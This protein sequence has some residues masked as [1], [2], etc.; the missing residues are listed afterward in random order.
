M[1]KNKLKVLKEVG[2]RIHKTCMFCAHKDIPYASNWGGCKLHTYNHLKHTKESK[3]LSIHKS[4]SCDSFE[5]NEDEL[6]TIHGFV[7]L[8]E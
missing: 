1:D 7:E 8:V 2:Y 4:G 3:P 5:M 6:L